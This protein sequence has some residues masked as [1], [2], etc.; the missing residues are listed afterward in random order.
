M[1]TNKK[2]IVSVVNDELDIS[3]LFHD[4]LCSIDGICVLSFNDPVVAQDHFTHNIDDY[5]LVVSD[6]RMPGLSGLDLLKKV[7]RLHQQVRTILM[8]AYGDENEKDFAYIDEGVVDKFIEKPITVNC[9]CE[10]VG[11]Q[12]LEYQLQTGI[13]L[14]ARHTIPHQNISSGNQNLTDKQGNIEVPN[15]VVPG[16]SPSVQ[17]NQQ[18]NIDHFT[19]RME[20]VYFLICESCFWCAS[21]IRNKTTFA[22]CPLC[23]N[24]KINCIPIGKDNDCF[25]DCQSKGVELK[26]A[27]NIRR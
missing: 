6:L 15:D 9:L 2:G 3:Q 13:K 4:T 8:T 1:L 25:I 21:F 22:N 10:A 17:I 7:K 5:I 26:L 20:E 12:L 23:R 27:N 24:G 11:N 19:K 18:S 14:S 16:I